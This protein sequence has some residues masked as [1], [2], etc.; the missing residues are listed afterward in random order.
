[1][2]SVKLNDYEI[3]RFNTLTKHLNHQKPHQY[4]AVRINDEG[5]VLILY[6]SAKLVY[7]ENKK[8]L[9]ILSLILNER[10]YLCS[11]P[12]VTTPKN[13]TSTQDNKLNIENYSNTIGSDE[14]GK[15]E[16]Y[17]PLV[18][19][20]TSTSNHENIQL[21][22]IGVKDS[23]KLSK[24]Q[25]FTL[26]H[27]IEKIGINYELIALKPFSYNKLYNKFK[28]EGKNLNHMLA[29]IHSKCITQLLAKMENTDNTLV[30]VDKFDYKKMNDY[31]NVDD[32]I[33]VVQQSNAERYTPVAAA[34]IIAKYHYEKILKQLDER[35]NINIKKQ[36]P[37][38]INKEILDKV[39]KTHFKNVAKYL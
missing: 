4:E 16:W 27:E 8:T 7:N 25:I 6:N 24:N 28:S 12:K 11:D 17:G 19:C 34:S 13:K 33:N 3:E 20:A 35:Y 14:T 9:D 2:K 29:H 21:R 23:K 10:R 38:D 18:V 37:K 15:G 39:A 26:Y 31:L 32:K 22:K 5:I 30:I 1:M 36:Q